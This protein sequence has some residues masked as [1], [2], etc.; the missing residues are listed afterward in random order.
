M[1][2]DAAINVI[3]LGPAMILGLWYPAAIYLL[4]VKNLTAS[5]AI[6]RY[7]SLV[8]AIVTGLHWLVALASMTSKVMAPVTFVFL[9]A[10]LAN[11][12]AMA[13]T[14]YQLSKLKKSQPAEG[15]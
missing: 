9:A 12:S 13:Y 11:V 15:I 6:A 5:V 1:L 14:F 8:I 3:I 2:F 7:A 10:E 4:V